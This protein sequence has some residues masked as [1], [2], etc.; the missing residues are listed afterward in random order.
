MRQL[1][2][3]P[4]LP[5]A[6]PATKRRAPYDKAH[7][8]PH[9]TSVSRRIA[10]S[11]PRRGRRSV[12]H[13]HERFRKRRTRWRAGRRSRLPHDDAPCSKPLNAARL[14]QSLRD[15]ATSASRHRRSPPQRRPLEEWAERESIIEIL[16]NIRSSRIRAIGTI[17]NASAKGRAATTQ[18]TAAIPNL[19]VTCWIGHAEPIIAKAGRISTAHTAISAA[20]DRR[21]NPEGAE[22]STSPITYGG[23][24]NANAP[25]L[26]ARLARP[27]SA[28]RSTLASRYIAATE[29]TLLASVC[30]VVQAEPATAAPEYSVGSTFV[31]VTALDAA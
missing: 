9:R 10:T 18:R 11:E 15:R 5:E 7:S 28:G 1:A 20:P 23:M 22:I 27:K 14:R 3:P 25:M 2:A 4:T 19:P 26:T 8:P 13:G 29:A 16:R 21:P 24:T 6:C 30:S 31:G 17:I 12:D